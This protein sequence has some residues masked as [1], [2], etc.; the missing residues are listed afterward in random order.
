MHAKSHRT[1]ELIMLI[2]SFRIIGGT[3]V[4]ILDVLNE[5]DQLRGSQKKT[6]SVLPHSAYSSNTSSNL[7]F[8]DVL[9]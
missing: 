5:D 1:T 7:E 3:A 6:Y 9:F 8:P 2:R 4:I